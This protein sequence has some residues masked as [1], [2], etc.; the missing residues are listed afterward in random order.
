MQ[1]EAS[2]WIT[3]IRAGFASGA[4]RV[5]PEQVTAARARNNDRAKLWTAEELLSK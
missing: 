2:N 5:S 1:G 4:A 3:Y